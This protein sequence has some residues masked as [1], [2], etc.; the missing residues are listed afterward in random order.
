MAHASDFSESAE[1]L[2]SALLMFLM[3]VLQALKKKKPQRLHN[4]FFSMLGVQVVNFLKAKE[5]L[6]F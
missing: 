2:V 5:T 1:M 6:C 4:G 3:D